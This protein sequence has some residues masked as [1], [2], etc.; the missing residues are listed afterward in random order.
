[1]DG[2]VQVRAVTLAG[3]DAV[4]TA[5]NALGPRVSINW[6]IAEFDFRIQFTRLCVP[7]LARHPARN[8]SQVR[9][10]PFSI[11]LRTAATRDIGPPILQTTF[12]TDASPQTASLPDEIRLSDGVTM[13][14]L[15]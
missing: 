13:I 12:E 8:R 14:F 11:W 15:H 2:E 4:L 1:M 10:N 9:C 7:V 3:C 6:F 5:R